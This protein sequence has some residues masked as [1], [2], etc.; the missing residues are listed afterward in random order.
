MRTQLFLFDLDGTL[1][2]TAPDLGGAVNDML[3]DRGLPELSMEV[4]RAPAGH[5][6][7]AL[8]RTAFGIERDDPKFPEMREEFL[9]NYRRRGVSHSPLFTGIRDLLR[10]LTEAGIACGIVTNKPI[11][12][13]RAVCDELDLTRHMAVVIG[14]GMPG[15]A[16][17]P[18]PDS[19]IKALED[20]GITAAH[21][22]YA[23]DSTF[24]AEAAHAAGLPFA[25]VAWG[26]QPSPTPADITELVATSPADLFEW[27]IRRG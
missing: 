21:A 14:V 24:D 22:V 20:T 13:T 3:R 17:K 23:G 2:D 15:T 7:P 26:C 1:V 8:L 4:L 18:K 25:W 5:G 10:A 6:A 19:L 27:A 16:V 12:L 11:E 9:E